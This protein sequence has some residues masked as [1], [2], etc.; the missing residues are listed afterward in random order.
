MAVIKVIGRPAS[1]G[2][3]PLA[4]VLPHRSCRAVGPF[5]F[6]DHF[7]PAEQQDMQVAPHP[8][9]GLHTLTWL[10][11]GEILHRDSL[12]TEAA[13]RP[14]EVNWMTAGAGITHSERTPNGQ[15]QD[16]HG[17]QCWVAQSRADEQGEP[18]FQHVSADDLPRFSRDGVRWTVV[19]G[20]WLEEHSPVRIN[21][22]T[23]FVEGRTEASDTWEWPY[24]AIWTMGIYVVSGSLTVSYDGNTHRVVAGELLVIPPQEQG[25]PQPHVEALAGVQFVC[26]GGEPLPEQRFFDWNFVASDPALLASARADWMAQRRFAPVPGDPERI[27]HPA[28]QDQDAPGVAEG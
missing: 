25:V 2:G 8:H 17:L 5:V 15:P 12:G 24:P 26:F 11:S 21:W 9:I 20:H 10:F 27:P 14:G 4:R 18:G 16:L 3:A 1:L 22:P 23:F 13:I 6:L 19:V 7:G 28:E